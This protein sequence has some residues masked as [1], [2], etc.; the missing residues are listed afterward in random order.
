MEWKR[1]HESE[2]SRCGYADIEGVNYQEHDPWSE[3]LLFG[4][5]LKNESNRPFVKEVKRVIDDKG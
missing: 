4:K 5:K 2:S 3:Y 1:A